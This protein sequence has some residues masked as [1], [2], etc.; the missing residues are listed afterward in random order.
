MNNDPYYLKYIKYKAKYL[1]LNM[2]KKNSNSQVGT[3]YNYSCGKCKTNFS[4]NDGKVVNT[5]ILIFSDMLPEKNGER[6][7]Y[8]LLSQRNYW[9][10]PGGNVDKKE[11]IDVSPSRC[12]KAL[13]REF[14][15]EV[16]QL[17]HKVIPSDT[18]VPSY[19]VYNERTNTC[20]RL[21]YYDIK[22][23][24]D[25][26][27]F[28]TIPINGTGGH[29]YNEVKDAQWLKLESILDGTISNIKYYVKNSMKLLRNN[30][31]I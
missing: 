1:N 16:G 14:S 6:H 29:G 18:I 25:L 8:M 3:G 10:T 21:Y 4:E 30:K 24:H 31:L 15:E 9:M 12:W 28:T 13:S 19:D 23:D 27:Q 11:E 2:I 17:I 26:L 5:A 7:V 22:S 20:T